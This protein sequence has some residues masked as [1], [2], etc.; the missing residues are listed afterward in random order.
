MLARIQRTF[1]YQENCE[2]IERSKSEGV[3]DQS[4]EVIPNSSPTL[5]GTPRRKK[6]QRRLERASDLVSARKRNIIV[7]RQS[8][9]TD[10]AAARFNTAIEDE[11]MSPQ[12]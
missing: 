12:K 5:P 6:R 2:I 10:H 9:P 11:P 7:G 1:L 4:N 8:W 3:Q